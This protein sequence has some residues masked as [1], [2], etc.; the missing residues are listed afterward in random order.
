MKTVLILECLSFNVSFNCRSLQYEFQFAYCSHKAI[1][2]FL[3]RMLN[4]EIKCTL[5]KLMHFYPSFVCSILILYDSSPFYE[6]K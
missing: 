6:N 3:A 1:P 4:F 2:S 5:V